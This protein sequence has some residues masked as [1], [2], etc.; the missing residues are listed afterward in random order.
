MA[1][2]RGVEIAVRHEGKTEEY[3]QFRTVDRT[4]RDRFGFTPS[5]AFDDG[6][7]RL[8][9]FLEQERHAPSGQA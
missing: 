9:A 5:I 1:R 6:L 4:M 2:V 8:T 3:I 7:Q